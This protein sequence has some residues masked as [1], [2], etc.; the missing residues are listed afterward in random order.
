MGLLD[1]LFGT[2]KRQDAIKSK[3]QSHRYNQGYQDGYRD[4]YEEG[5]CE[6][7]DCDCMNQHTYCCQ[8]DSG[9]HLDD[10]L[11]HEDDMCADEY[12]DE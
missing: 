6:D 9:S 7:W 5:S 12:E 8:E 2:H 1:F 11:D 3:A 4:A 10:E